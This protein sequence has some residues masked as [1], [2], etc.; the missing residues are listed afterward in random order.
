MRETLKV[1]WL[2]LKPHSP[3]HPTTSLIYSPKPTLPV[4]ID[5][6]RYMYHLLSIINYIYYP[7]PLY[8]SSIPNYCITPPLNSSSL[9]YYWSFHLVDQTPLMLLLQRGS[10]LLKP[11]ERYITWHNSSPYASDLQRNIHDQISKSRYYS[12]LYSTIR[13]ILNLLVDILLLLLFLYPD[14]GII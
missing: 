7:L 6:H 8:L 1:V 2:L 4:C 5:L 10:P 14:I 12:Y 9:I 13:S 3:I 11:D